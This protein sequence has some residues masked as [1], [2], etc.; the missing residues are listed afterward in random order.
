MEKLSVNNASLTM[1]MNGDGGIKDDCIITKYENHLF[2]VL[3]AGC[4]DKDV[5]HLYDMQKEFKG[6]VSLV[7]L[8]KRSLIA[9]QGPKSCSMLSKYI[10]NISLMNFM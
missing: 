7:P 9:V 6:D 5:A 1:L 2:I 8:H 10:N 4:K 3:N